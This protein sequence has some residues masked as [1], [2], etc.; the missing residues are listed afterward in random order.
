MKAAKSKA[1]A[2]KKAMK[3][4]KTVGAKAKGKAMKKAMKAMKTVGAKATGK[5]MRWGPEDWRNEVPMGILFSPAFR[6]WLY[7]EDGEDLD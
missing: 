7:V 1:K 6:P 3:A 5:A 2:M 4:M